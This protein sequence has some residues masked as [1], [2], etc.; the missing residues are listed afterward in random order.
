MLFHITEKVCFMSINPI[1][2]MVVK[3]TEGLKLRFDDIN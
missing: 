3:K 1:R 2:I